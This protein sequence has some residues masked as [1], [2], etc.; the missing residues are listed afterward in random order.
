MLD[1][2]LRIRESFGERGSSLLFPFFNTHKTK[3]VTYPQLS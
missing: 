3:A 1:S 2:G